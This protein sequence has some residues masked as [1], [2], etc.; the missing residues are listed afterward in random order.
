[1][2]RLKTICV[3]LA[4]LSLAGTATANSSAK[5]DNLEQQRERLNAYH[6]QSCTGPVVAK[7]CARVSAA[8]N[9]LSILIGRLASAMQKD[10]AGAAFERTIKPSGDSRLQQQ[11][12]QYVAKLQTVNHQIEMMLQANVPSSNACLQGLQNEGSVIHM[13]L[14][15][16]QSRLKGTS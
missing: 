5:L 4:L 10:I 7:D 8:I 1:M 15:R 14:L 16:L 12:N 11:Y 2:L 3:G 13:R 6:A 9:K